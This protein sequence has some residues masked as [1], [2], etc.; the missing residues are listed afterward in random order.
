M[1]QK[2]TTS[3]TTETTQGQVTQDTTTQQ[4]EMV[5]EV[6]VTENE[7]EETETGVE[8]GAETETEIETVTTDAEMQKIDDDLASIKPQD[9]MT[10]YERLMKERELQDEL[11]QVENPREKA[12]SEFEAKN[13]A[14][15]ASDQVEFVLTMM[16]KDLG[17][18]NTLQQL[19]NRMAEQESFDRDRLL[20]HLTDFVTVLPEVRSRAKVTVAQLRSHYQ[21]LSKSYEVVEKLVG[22][23]LELERIMNYLVAM[24]KDDGMEEDFANY[25]SA[26]KSLAK[27]SNTT[28]FEDVL[29][30]VNDR[31]EPAT[32]LLANLV[33]K[34]MPRFRDHVRKACDVWSCEAGVGIGGGGNYSAF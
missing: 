21:T 7:K 9:V 5:S 32:E 23:V 6:V 33:S 19:I 34:P 2:E 22:C 26:L 20:M 4:T 30:H 11:W 18:H 29:K 28:P 17:M 1:D 27:L 8:A 12:Q 16:R 24:T 10:A 13:N 3:V 25:V 31:M 14:M 15:N